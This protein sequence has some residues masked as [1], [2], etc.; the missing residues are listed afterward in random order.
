MVREIAMA[1]L[2]LVVT[3]LK[4]ARNCVHGPEPVPHTAIYHC[5]QAAE[6]LVK[7]AMVAEG[8][9]PPRSHDIGI[10]VD[11]LA[12]DNP[13]RPFLERLDELT[14]F[15]VAYRYPSADDLALPPEPSVL[16]V[17]AWV[18]RIEKARAAFLEGM[19]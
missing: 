4:A 14:V 19:K 6:K 8:I 5:Q 1:W 12:L 16:D 17:D 15:A 10:L 13:L 11:R 3:D 7:A 9:N 18:D 2:D